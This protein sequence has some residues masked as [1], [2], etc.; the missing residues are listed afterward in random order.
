LQL[1]RREG[2]IHLITVSTITMPLP[3][4]PYSDE[5]LFQSLNGCLLGWALLVL[6]P[7]WRLTVPIVTLMCCVYSALYVGCVAYIM[8]QGA[9]FCLLKRR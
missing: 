4:L 8:L 9:T 2:C 7:R 6:F 3:G 5:Q 1:P